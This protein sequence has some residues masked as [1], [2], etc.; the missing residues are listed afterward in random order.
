MKNKD[1]KIKLIIWCAIILAGLVF[2]NNKA[3]AVTICVS[4]NTNDG[5]IVNYLSGGTNWGWNGSHCFP[6]HGLGW[7]NVTASGATS[8]SP[9]DQ[10]TN[11]PDATLSWT[12][13]FPSSGPPP[14]PP[15]P[16]EPPPPPPPKS[17]PT[18]DG[19]TPSTVAVSNES[20]GYFVVYGVKHASSVIVRVTRA[21][22]TEAEYYNASHITGGD[23]GVTVNHSGYGIF[24]VGFWPDWVHCVDS[25]FIKNQP[26]GTIQITSNKPNIAFYLKRTDGS[27]AGDRVDG[28]GNKTYTGYVAGTYSI[29][30]VE[31][32]SGYKATWSPASATLSDGGAISFNINYVGN[33]ATSIAC[34]P[35]TVSSGGSA[36]VSWSSSNANSCTVSPTG[37]TGI[38]GSKSTKPLFSSQTYSLTCTNN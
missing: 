17:G 1:L 25:T 26:G 30:R 15:P 37:W 34:T 16:P 38:S 3:S 11:D 20:G 32:I 33:P 8:V 2:A 23:W 4:A 35:T 6:D 5:Y 7:Y 36:D 19:V 10:N 22:D 21:G 31:D 28:S 18:C 13:K 9:G 29:D 14:P 24:N 12:V 27:V